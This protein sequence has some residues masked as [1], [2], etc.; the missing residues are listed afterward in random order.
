MQSMCSA[1]PSS[2]CIL[3]DGIANR[4]EPPTSAG[5][6]PSTAVANTAIRVPIVQHRIE[7]LSQKSNG[8]ST[9]YRMTLGFG[10]LCVHTANRSELPCSRPPQLIPEQQPFTTTW[11]R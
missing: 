3:H 5:G 11:C 10:K 6:E 4:I 9:V 1:C 2:R 7:Q 8:N